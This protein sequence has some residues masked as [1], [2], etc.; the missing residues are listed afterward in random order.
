MSGKDEY[1]DMI[2]GPVIRSTNLHTIGI[3]M[4]RTQIT[5]LLLSHIAENYLV[6]SCSY[7]Y[8][9]E[10]SFLLF[11]K[12]DYRIIKVISVKDVTRHY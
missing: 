11:S 12:S 4:K 8:D 9:R 3:I 2:M 6:A 7:Q 5:S 10:N 1:I